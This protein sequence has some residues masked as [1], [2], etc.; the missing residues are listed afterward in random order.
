MFSWRL[1]CDNDYSTLDSTS[2]QFGQNLHGQTCI[3]TLADLAQVGQILPMGE[4]WPTCWV[5]NSH[6][7]RKG[8]YLWPFMGKF[9]PNY[10]GKKCPFI[11]DRAINDHLWA[12]FAQIISV[13]NGQ[14]FVAKIPILYCTIPYNELMKGYM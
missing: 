14:I 12:N 2:S 8:Q 6:L 13:K 9:C 10:L 7:F 3:L 4:K 5:N 11:L 1:W